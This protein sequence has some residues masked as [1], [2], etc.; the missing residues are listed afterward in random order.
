MKFVRLQRLKPLLSDKELY[1]RGS[2]IWVELTGSTI[3]SKI[4]TVKTT[5]WDDG[6]QG[7]EEVVAGSLINGTIVVKESIS[8]IMCLV[9][10]D[11]G[12]YYEKREA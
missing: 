3:E 9:N 1:K 8:E 5:I 12:K 10:G 2:A 6:P 7:K 11:G 4:I